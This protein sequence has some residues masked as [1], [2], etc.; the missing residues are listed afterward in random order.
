[1]PGR[2][3]FALLAP[4]CA[5]AQQSPRS[6]RGA[7]GGAASAVAAAGTCNVG[8]HVQ[9]PG[10]GKMCS[11]DQCCPGVPETDNISFPCPSAAPSF[12]GC[13]GRGKVDNCVP[14][15]CSFD[16]DRTLT[17][18]QG[19]LEAC[20]DNQELPIIDTAY[21]GGNLT[22]SP[23]GQGF[24][25]TFCAGCYTGIVTAGDASG[26]QSDER[27]LLVHKMRTFGKLVSTEWA[28]PSLHGEGRANCSG[29]EVNTTLVVG[30]DDGT[31]QYALASAVA[32]V[33]STE[34]V[35]IAP[36]HVWHFDDRDGNVLAFSGTG[37]NAR[38]VSCG[39]RDYG[40]AVGLCGATHAEIVPS[41]GVVV[42]SEPEF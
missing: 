1:M 26:W 3:L 33:E 28:G 5:L 8:D 11:G 36:E 31:K 15:F 32:W 10:S 34:N 14:C 7:Y 18:K 16:V 42:C 38:M 6:L 29:L 17:G 35:T 9:C 21:G 19:D 20:P 13:E 30:C 27:G 39:T 22:L 4:W 2:A 37:F 24:A 23:V 12:Q 40:G 25:P 41:S